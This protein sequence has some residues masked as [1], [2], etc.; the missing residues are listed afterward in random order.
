MSDYSEIFLE[1]SIQD[2]DFTL[3]VTG[4]SLDQIQVMI[5]GITMEDADLSDQAPD[6]QQKSVSKIGDLWILGRHR[7]LCGDSTKSSDVSR[8]MSGH[9]ASVAFADSPYGV[10]YI[11]ETED[12]LRGKHRPILNDNLG[13]QFPEFLKAVCKNILSVTDDGI[14]I[15]MS[16]TALIPLY[17][18]FLEAGG[19]FSTFIIW[20]KQT[21]TLGRSDYQRQY[22]PMLY[23]WPKGSDHYWCGDRDQGDVWFFNKPAKNDLHPTMKPV[24]L[25]MRAIRNSSRRDEIVFDPFIGSGTTLIAAER[26]S[27][28]C[29]GI[30]LDPRYVDVCIR[31]WQSHTGGR[32][33]HAVGGRLFDDIAM[34]THHE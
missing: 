33:I 20:A 10:D 19:H 23:G 30:E 21:F 26:T 5:E 27:R 17:S 34:E 7:L 31:R 12:K 3:D 6:P 16:S 22:E 32:A 13:D 15:C 11:N 18:A 24:E 4:F 2:L 28:V 8:V 29:H 9:R 14:Y 1:L 25:V